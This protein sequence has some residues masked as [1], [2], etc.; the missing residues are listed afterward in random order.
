MQTYI[1]TVALT[2]EDV[3]DQAEQLR[4]LVIDECSPADEALDMHV[5]ESV[6]V[7]P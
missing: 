5:T 1:F 3:Q 2:G 6:R 4:Q 7:T